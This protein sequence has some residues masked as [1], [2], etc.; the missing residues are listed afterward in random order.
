MS[1]TLTVTV[2]R[3][4]QNASSTVIDKPIDISLVETYSQRSAGVVTVLDTSTSP[5]FTAISSG[6]ITSASYAQISS[7][8]NLSI[9]LNSMVSSFVAN[10]FAIQGTLTKIEVQNSSGITA[11]VSYDIRG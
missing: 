1:N 3:N 2:S 4:D 11:N 8:Q 9:K 7:D 6:G 10:F 5:V